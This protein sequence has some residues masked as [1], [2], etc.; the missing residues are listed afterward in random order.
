MFD[1]PCSMHSQQTLISGSDRVGTAALVVGGS[2]INDCGG[3]TE[4]PA[5]VTFEPSTRFALLHVPVLVVSLLPRLYVHVS[6]E[7]TFVTKSV[8]VESQPPKFELRLASVISGV[9][10][11]RSSG[12]GTISMELMVVDRRDVVQF[13][14]ARVQAVLVQ[15]PRN[16]Y[17]MHKYMFTLPYKPVGGANRGASSAYERR[18]WCNMSGVTRG[19]C[20]AF[21]ALCGKRSQHG[22]AHRPWSTQLRQYSMVGTS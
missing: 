14:S 2:Q 22:G 3:A 18:K 12:S 17:C 19:F 20:C 5:E 10:R 11:T 16:R 8:P 13:P 6:G 9:K 7:E 21:V 15:G 4:T 1:R